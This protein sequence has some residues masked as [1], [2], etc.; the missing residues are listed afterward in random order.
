MRTVFKSHNEVCHIF[1]TLEGE[2]IF[3]RHGSK[4]GNIFFD[5]GKLYSYGRHYTIAKY[6][7][8]HTLLFSTCSY[9]NSTNKHLSIARSA[10]SHKRLIFVPDAGASFLSNCNSWRREALMIKDK[11]AVARKPEKYISQL[12]HILGQAQI[13]ADV[14]G[15]Q[16]TAELMDAL[17]HEVTDEQCQ[18]VRDRA[19]ADRE[20]NKQV[21]AERLKRWRDFDL[22]G[23]LYGSD[24][25]YLRVRPNEYIETSKGVKMDIA[26]AKALYLKIKEVLSLNC[27]D[28][29]RGQR[30]LKLFRVTSLTD[31]QFV[32]GCHTIPMEEIEKVATELKWEGHQ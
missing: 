9:S 20:R 21:F 23:N 6:L 30:I 14:I 12:D 25:V 32:V 10:L 27:P 18:A 16:L 8:E 31:K 3:N 24:K 22:F 26:D 1:A 28:E 19:K 2:E 5:G 15:M 7:D 29:L 17:S 11:L 4:A 13:Y